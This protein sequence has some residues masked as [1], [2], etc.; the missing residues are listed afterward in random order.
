MHQL[1]NKLTIKCCTRGC[2]GLNDYDDED[3]DTECTD[4][5]VEAEVHG[6][7]AQYYPEAGTSS[8][9]DSDD[10]R[11]SSDVLESFDVGEIDVGNDGGLIES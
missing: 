3:D 10:S 7:V 11:A 4:G 6:A 9:D 5:K 1:L 2:A 8:E